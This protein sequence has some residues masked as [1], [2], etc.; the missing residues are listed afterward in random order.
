MYNLYVLLS[1]PQYEE[2]YPNIKFEFNW[3]GISFAAAAYSIA[4]QM[5]S[6]ATVFMYLILL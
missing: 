5:S 1:S 3:R 6:T 4:F 2:F